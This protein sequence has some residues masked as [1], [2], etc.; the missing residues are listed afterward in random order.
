MAF[1]YR[2]VANVDEVPEGET[3]VFDIAG[4]R[5]VLCNVGGSFYAVEDVCTHDGSP[6]GIE[7]L[8][9]PVIECPRHGARFDVR[10]GSVL[11]MPAVA[12][13]R[14]FVTRVD[15]SDVFVAVD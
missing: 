8:E 5:I 6:F 3:R 15:G 14:T 1:E 11:R 2:R 13:L 10:T 4:E 9:G 7:T 12:P